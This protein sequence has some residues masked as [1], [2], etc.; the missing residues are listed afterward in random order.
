M[1][2]SRGGETNKQNPWYQT[3]SMHNPINDAEAPK[4]NWSTTRKSKE[5]CEQSPYNES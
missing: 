2:V 1:S 5:S 3:K 4:H